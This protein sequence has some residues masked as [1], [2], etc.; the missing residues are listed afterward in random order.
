MLS[1]QRVTIIHIFCYH[2]LFSYIFVIINIDERRCEQMLWQLTR[3]L[4]GGRYKYVHNFFFKRCQTRPVPGRAGAAARGGA[5]ARPRGGRRARRRGA[6]SATSPAAST[7]TCEIV[8]AFTP[9]TNCHS[10]SLS[11]GCLHLRGGRCHLHAVAVRC[12]CA[13]VNKTPLAAP[14]SLSSL[15]FLPHS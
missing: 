7:F 5:R 8:V 9:A 11:L 12:Q 6:T 2:M 1:L 13:E 15:A 4:E 3:F 10:S 14:R